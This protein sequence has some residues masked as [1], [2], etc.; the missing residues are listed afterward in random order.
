MY[1]LCRLVAVACAI[2]LGLLAQVPAREW[3]QQRE[4]E[5][6]AAEQTRVTEQARQAQEREIRRVDRQQAEQQRQYAEQ[7]RQYAEQQRAAQAQAEQQRLY[8][9]QQTAQ[10]QKKQESGDQALA[11]M[12]A[13]VQGDAVVEAAPQAAVQQSPAPHWSV[14]HFSRRDTVGLAALGVLLVA[15]ACAAGIVP[16]RLSTRR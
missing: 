15:L 10:V 11:P 2:P 3:A 1:F 13:V 14:S 8:Q 4:A 9:L 5:R 6:R 16:I 12:P 7:Q